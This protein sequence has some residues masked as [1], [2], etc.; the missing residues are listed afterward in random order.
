MQSPYQIRPSQLRMQQ[1]PFPQLPQ[2]QGW[3][4]S[5]WCC[6]SQPS[7]DSRP[8]TSS[9]WHIEGFLWQQ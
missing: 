8:S 3:S 2:K 9:V 7:A 1:Q 6:S 4:L 5:C